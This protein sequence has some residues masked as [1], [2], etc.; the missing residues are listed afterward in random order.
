E[1]T[2]RQWLETRTQ[3]L[4]DKHTALIEQN[5]QLQQLDKFLRDK[6]HAL[7]SHA[8]DLNA[9]L[10][11]TQNERETEISER[12]RLEAH[13]AELASAHTALTNAL[14]R[15]KQSEATLKRAYEE[16]EGRFQ[17]QISESANT[18]SEL[19][20]EVSE[21]RQLETRVAKLSSIQNR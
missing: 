9:Q 2:K 13:A 15:S 8:H 12:K 7:D 21:R 5:N 18:R 19:Q 3:E 14:E 17:T 16:L 11:R 10:S 6:E 20:R 4:S 1:S